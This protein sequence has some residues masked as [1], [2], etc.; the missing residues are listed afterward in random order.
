MRH[1]SVEPSTHIRCAARPRLLRVRAARAQRERAAD[2]VP[3]FEVRLEDRLSAPYTL[4]SRVN[5]ASTP[6]R[7]ADRDAVRGGNAAVVTRRKDAGSV[8]TGR[9]S[10]RTLGSDARVRLPAPP[11]L[12]ESG[13]RRP[14]ASP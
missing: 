12:R 5:A 11:A 7:S 6:R 4:V 13:G 3:V 1:P 10:A 8:R 9:S 2:A 14:S